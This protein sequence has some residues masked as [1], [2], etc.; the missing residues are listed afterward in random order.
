MDIELILKLLD[1]EIRWC[2]ENTVDAPSR[3]YYEG[4]VRGLVQAKIVLSNAN[5]EI[6]QGYIGE[7]LNKQDE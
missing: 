1:N 7:Q 6:I 5:S 2:N 3:A 4:F